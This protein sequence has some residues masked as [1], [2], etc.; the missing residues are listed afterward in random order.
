MSCFHC[1][2]NLWA[3]FADGRS[4]VTR[5]NEHRQRPRPF[6]STFP[7]Q[8]TDSSCTFNISLRPYARACPRRAL[9]RRDEEV[10]SLCALNK[11]LTCDSWGDSPHKGPRRRAC[12]WRLPRLRRDYAM[13]ATPTGGALNG[14]FSPGDVIYLLLQGNSSEAF[15]V[16]SGGLSTLRQL[17]VER[18]ILRERLRFIVTK[19]LK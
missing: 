2:A 14:F 10:V 17:R 12:C 7:A 9:C 16:L 4:F 3:L 18:S 8:Q 11:P 1:P 5:R 19:N 6:R 13:A 15:C